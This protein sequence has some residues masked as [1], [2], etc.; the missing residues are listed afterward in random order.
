MPG[1][2]FRGEPPVPHEG[3]MRNVRH[4]HGL[5]LPRAVQQPEHYRPLAVVGG[6]PSISEHLAE[7]K[8][9]PGDVW[10]IN[11]ACGFLRKAGI[12]SVMVACDPHEIVAK[13]AAGVKRAMLCSRCDPAAFEVL[14][15]AEV[16]VF[17]LAQDDPEGIVCG[18]STATGCFHLGVR[19][20]Y[21][22]IVFFGC[23][24]SYP[25][26]STHAYQHE[27]REHELA[28]ECGGVEYRTAP[29]YYEQAKELAAILRKFPMYFSEK[30]GGLLRAMVE[31]EKHDITKV[32]P[33]LLAS[34]TPDNEESARLQREALREHLQLDAD[35]PEWHEAWRKVAA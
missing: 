28:V 13:W 17:D 4:A 20:G 12:D 32:S 25:K 2:V 8:A 10:A 24:S 27:A 34:L 15:D 11:G 7:L 19:L 18:S 23:E 3:M 5:G 33:R 9:W 1:I 16:T 22:R 6:G 30:S 21:R 29:D 31:H 14:K 35:P 26:G